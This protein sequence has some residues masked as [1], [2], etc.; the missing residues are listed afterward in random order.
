MS[1]ATTFPKNI[2]LIRHGATAW[3]E[4]GQ[5]TG[6]TDLPL[7]PRGIEQAKQLAHRLQRNKFTQVFSSPLKRA[8]QT[9]SLCN[10]TPVLDPNL[11]EWNY[12][13]YEGKT[14]KEIGPQWNL[15]RDGAPN[16]E[17]VSQV[18]ARAINFLK[19]IEGIEGTIAVFS[20]AHLLRMMATVWLELPPR[21]GRLFLLSPA[22]ISILGFEH[23]SKIIICWN[24]I[25]H[26][27]ML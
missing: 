8:M 1:H 3:S 19:K 18:Q 26:L 24:D 10:Y 20:S 4:T 5:H 14:S 11:A 17:S 2:V 13:D 25:A 15:W 6:I 16:G 9:C 12:G 7:E 23:Q 22:S 27:S 21:D